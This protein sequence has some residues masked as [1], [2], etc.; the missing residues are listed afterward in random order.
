ML[1]FSIRLWLYNLAKTIFRAQ[2]FQHGVHLIT[3]I[4]IAQQVNKVV[5]A[6][7]N[8]L[9]NPTSLNHVSGAIMIYVVKEL[10]EIVLRLS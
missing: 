4:F 5:K 2:L 6:Q 7:Y 9:R 1:L 10:S 8:T 3:L